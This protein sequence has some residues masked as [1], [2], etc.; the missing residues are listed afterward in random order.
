MTN[1][2][3]FLYKGT[4]AINQA[5]DFDSLTNKDPPQLRPQNSHSMENPST[6]F[7][8]YINLFIKLCTHI[9]CRPK[10]GQR[11]SKYVL[12]IVFGDVCFL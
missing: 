9:M 3:H 1:I 11:N 10:K 4:K 8:P 6:Y 12:L 7:M 5:N 2:K